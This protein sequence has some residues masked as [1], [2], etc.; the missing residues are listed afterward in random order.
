MKARKSLAS[1]GFA[2]SLA[3]PLASHADVTWVTTNDEAGTRIVVTSTGNTAAPVAQSRALAAGGLNA[4]RDYVYLGEEA[5]WQLRPMQYRIEGG[6]LVHVDDPAG[7]MD[8]M[9][10][11]SPESPAQRR[12]LELSGG[13]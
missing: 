11:A 13:A 2:L 9:A 8:R 5:G 10:D 12:A 4:A 6:R 1:L 7:H 3:A